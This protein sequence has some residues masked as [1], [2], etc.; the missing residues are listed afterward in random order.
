MYVFWQEAPRPA[1]RP[2]ARPPHRNG[3]SKRSQREHLSWE[4]GFAVFAF[5]KYRQQ[6]VDSVAL[7]DPS[8]LQWILR[9]GFPAHVQQVV[10]D[11]LQGYSTACN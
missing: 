1:Q 11:A 9:Q 2:P 4:T 6:T 10:H 3:D 7:Q 5:G 8:Y